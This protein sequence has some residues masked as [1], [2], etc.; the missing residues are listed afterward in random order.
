ME[1]KR[2]Q[3]ISIFLYRLLELIKNVLLRKCCF[4]RRVEFFLQHTCS[5][6]LSTNIQF[7]DEDNLRKFVYCDIETDYF[8]Q[9]SN[10]DEVEQK[11]MKLEAKSARSGHFNTLSKRPSADKFKHRSAFLEKYF[12]LYYV[13]I[14]VKISYVNSIIPNFYIIF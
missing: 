8:L 5:C 1:E 6:I 3:Y 12:Y 11:R 13:P 9:T 7:F 10:K 4:K 2:S 14:I